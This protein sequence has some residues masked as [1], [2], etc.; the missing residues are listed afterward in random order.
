MDNPN[1]EMVFKADKPGTTRGVVI[2]QS[3]PE[4]ETLFSDKLDIAKAVDRTKIILGVQNKLPGLDV[5]KIEQWLLQESGKAVVQ[6]PQAQEGKSPT[7][8][9]DVSRIARPQ[10]FFAPEVCGLIIPGA[11]L[12]DNKPV[13]YW[14]QY[15]QWS[16]G[17]RQCSNLAESILLPDGQKLWFS[18]N[19]SRPTVMDSPN[20]SKEIRSSWLGEYTPRIDKV[21]TDLI[22]VYDYFLEFKK[23][24]EK[25]HLAT[26]SLWTILTYVYP[27]WPAVP[28][29]SIGGP[30][31]SGKSRIF[32]V[33]G[34]LAFSPI[35]SSNM[36]SACLFRTVHDRGGTLLLDEAER[37]QDQS[38]DMAEI[39]SILL[40]GYKAGQM[41]QRLEK[42]DDGFVRVNFDV[43]GPKAVACINEL[44]A[45]LASRCIRIMMFR[46]SKGSPKPSRQLDSYSGWC[47]LRDH[48]HCIA[49]SMG[50]VLLLHSKKSVTCD[51]L[52][53][54]DMEIWTPILS[55]ARFIEENTD[56][57]DLVTLVERHAQ[58]TVAKQKDESIAPTDEAVLMSINQLLKSHIGGVTASQILEKAKEE[59]AAL[60]NRTSARGISPILKRYGIVSKK[61]GG[62][63]LFRPS[64]ADLLAIQE[65]YGIDLGI[66]QE[67]KV[68]A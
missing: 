18:P 47:T 62:L 33:L 58:E 59:E 15:L 50:C 29:L 44:P 46:A 54:R 3:K 45:P 24:E 22:D 23:E 49:L 6:E 11:K 57:D 14:R 42:R 32:D 31:G 34:R 27:I 55:L 63:R 36:T 43:F 61:I 20:W 51:K 12:E 17:Q 9:V 10:L 60:F 1:I 7:Q 48:L 25:G 21:F 64:Q 40:A 66:P 13:G 16:N 67:Q 38:S 53:G 68:S 8:E 52:Y 35:I 37:L 65:A 28:Y 41:A 4:G 2:I 5:E 39:R 30:Q 19:P 56:I 26:L